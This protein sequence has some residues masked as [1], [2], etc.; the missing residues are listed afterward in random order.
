MFRNV[1]RNRSVVF[2][3]YMANCMDSAKVF[4][5]TTAVEEAGAM[6]RR[7]AVAVTEQHNTRRLINRPRT[8][9]PIPFTLGRTESVSRPGFVDG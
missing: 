8:S 7:D 6:S 2:V 9:G 4:E 5:I 1:V 3:A